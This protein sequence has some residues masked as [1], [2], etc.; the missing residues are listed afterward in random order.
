MTYLSG[1]GSHEFGMA[2]GDSAGGGEG[3][4]GFGVRRTDF[5]TFNA[6]APSDMVF[7]RGTLLD[8]R[9]GPEAATGADS[10]AVT[11]AGAGA[12]AGDGAGWTRWVPAL[13]LFFTRWMAAM[14]SATSADVGSP[15]A[16]CGVDWRSM[17][18][19][20]GRGG[21]RKGGAAEIGGGDGG[22]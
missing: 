3:V 6:L 18:S 20:S 2:S 11:K 12:V 8:D 19:E 16:G 17:P 22:S 13:F 14:T 21:A 4:T 9:A 15:P 10:T 1:S 5:F 7:G